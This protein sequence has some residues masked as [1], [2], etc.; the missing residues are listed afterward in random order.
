VLFLA[1]MAAV[2]AGADSPTPDGIYKRAAGDLFANVPRA[3]WRYTRYLSLQAIPESERLKFVQSLHFTVNSLSWR[4]TIVHPEVIGEDQI[5]YRIDLESLGWDRD[6]RIAQRAEWERRGVKFKFKDAREEK[7]FLDPWDAM[8]QKE[9]YFKTSAKVN[10]ELIRGWIDPVVAQQ[11]S[12][13]TYSG[14]FVLRADWFLAHAW[15]EKDRGGFYSL[16]LMI[17]PTEQELYKVLL[18]PIDTVERAAQLRYGGAVAKSIVAFHNRGLEVFYSPYGRGAKYFWR[19]YDVLRDDLPE[20]NIHVSTGGTIV[21]DGRETIGSLPNGFQFYGVYDGKGKQVEVVPQGIAL[22]M[23]RETLDQDRNVINAIKC[24]SCHEAGINPYEDRIGFSILHPQ[25]GLAPFSKDKAR[26]TGR[27][28]ELSDYYRI[29]EKGGLVR[30]VLRHQEAYAEA[31]FDANELTPEDN[32]QRAVG[33]YDDYVYRLVSLRQASR[34]IG[35]PVEDTR[36]ALQLAVRK[37]VVTPTIN[38]ATATVLS[39]DQGVSRT[40]F[41]ASFGNIMRGIVHPWEQ[42]IQIKH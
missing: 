15:T 31:V 33:W 26:A 32:A 22:D 5:L 35:L 6:S 28:Y 19:T 13:A 20:K 23:R 2:L 1:A 8:V 11:A 18:I 21:H 14:S 30:E 16:F 42:G 10:G 17:P 41:E 3:K 9:P 4:S 12:A 29:A 39:S 24:V 25:I 37:G 38:D 36:K 34:E 40:Q 7:L 27:A